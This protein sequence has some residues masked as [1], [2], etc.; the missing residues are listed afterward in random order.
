LTPLV[1]AFDGIVWLNPTNGHNMLSIEGDNGYSCLYCH[2][3][4]DTPGTHDHAGTPDYAYAPGLKSGDHVVAGQLVAWVGDSGN[5]RGGEPH[6]H[7]ELTCRG[8]YLNPAPSLRAARKLTRPVYIP[9]QQQLRPAKG[10]VRLDGSVR[11]YDGKLLVLRVVFW[12][13]AKG[14]TVAQ[15]HP[16]RRYIVI[17]PDTQLRRRDQPDQRL[18]P[19]EI[20][21]GL[22]L[23]VLGTDHGAERAVTA[24]LAAADPLQTRIAAAQNTF[25]ASPDDLP[26]P[27]HRPQPAPIR[28]VVVQARALSEAE[29]RLVTL[30]NDFRKTNNLD[31]LSLDVRLSRAALD[32]SADMSDHHFLAHYG[33]DGS[34]PQ[35]RAGRAGYSAGTV[36]ENLATGF[37]DPDDV[38]EAWIHRSRES[39]RNLLD[40]D[41]R[42]IGVAHTASTQLGAAPSHL[43]HAW[44]VVLAVDPETP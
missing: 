2:I 21:P 1:A 40:P 5:A 36:V 26:T 30:I 17:A 11:S 38:F 41:L 13:D 19:D 33:T 18:Q 3:N 35:E 20:K 22:P 24:R 28:P 12:M 7:F 23:I 39:R 34:S 37:T 31:P 32:Q 16:R 29:L 43:D 25:A 4:D 27:P 15:S 42:R 10:E 14:H 44:T 8:R 6:C 9:P